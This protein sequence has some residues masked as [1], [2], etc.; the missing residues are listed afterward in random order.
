MLSTRAPEATTWLLVRRTTW[1]CTATSCWRPSCGAFLE[2]QS[3]GQRTS[4]AGL[5][6]RAPVFAYPGA[7]LQLGQVAVGH[8]SRLGLAQGCLQN[9]Q[10]RSE[11]GIAK[12]RHGDL[13]RGFR[14]ER[15]AS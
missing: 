6:A 8:V 15:A 5:F 1:R 13:N 10:T 4:G 7:P 14:R 2:E 11:S 9:E 3:G 12:Y